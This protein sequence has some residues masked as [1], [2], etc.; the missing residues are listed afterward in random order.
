MLAADAL[1]K[2]NMYPD[3]RLSVYE[4]LGEERDGIL[5]QGYQIQNYKFLDNSTL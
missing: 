2:Y 4:R 3:L 5:A 1:E